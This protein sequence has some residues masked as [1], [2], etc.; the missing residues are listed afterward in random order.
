MIEELRRQLARDEG[1]RAKPY[2]DT[3]GHL[4]IGIGRNLDDVGLSDD[5]I[6]YL[7]E[8]DLRRTEDELLRVLPWVATL[9]EAR[10]GVLL[11]MSFN[12][13]V[14]GL[15]EF[16]KMLAAVERGDWE[17]AAQEMGDSV[18]A[19]Q[20]GGRAARLMLQMRTGDWI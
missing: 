20:V 6:D 8:H 5:E 1:R 3:T 2:T 10:L 11:N 13:G 16:R 18:W 4:T 17:T 7:F 12:L 9:D 14:A 15:L 19:T